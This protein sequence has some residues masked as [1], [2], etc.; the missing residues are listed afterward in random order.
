MF[1]PDHI[2]ED[3][4]SFSRL[5]S[6]AALRRVAKHKLSPYVAAAQPLLAQ[7]QSCQSYEFVVRLDGDNP[8]T[9][10]LSVSRDGRLLPCPDRRWRLRRGCDQ[11]G[12]QALVTFTARNRP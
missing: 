10:W 1:V 5:V 11:G 8:S 6:S 9:R 7:G 3:G 2:D 4:V 12:G